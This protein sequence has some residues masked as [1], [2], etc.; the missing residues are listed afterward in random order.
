MTTFYC[1]ENN[2]NKKTRELDASELSD[3][4][5]EA[6]DTQEITGSTV[7]IVS[8]EYDFLHRIHTNKSSMGAIFEGSEW[9]TVSIR[10]LVKSQIFSK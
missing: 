8:E 10:K 2:N 4:K 6:L 5:L 9:L 1:F 7:T 3:A